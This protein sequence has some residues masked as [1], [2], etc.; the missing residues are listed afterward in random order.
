MRIRKV[1][2]TIAV[3]VALMIISAGSAQ[4]DSIV[5]SFTGTGAAINSPFVTKPAISVAFQL[6]VPN[7][8]NPPFPVGFPPNP[9]S[10]ANFTCAQLDSSTNCSP[11]ATTITL[12]NQGTGPLTA[13]LQFI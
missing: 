9:L 5:Y 11:N 2:P 1:L 13:D 12:S 10:F 7:F 6:T 3:V 8:I 4:A